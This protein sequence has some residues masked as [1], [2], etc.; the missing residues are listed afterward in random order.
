MKLATRR[1]GTRDGRLLVVSRDLQSAVEAVDIATT[2]QQA[3]ENWQVARPRLEAVFEALQA[4]KCAGAFRLQPEQLAAPLPRAY[5][6][7]DASA[8]HSHGDLLEQVFNLQPPP[9][10][11]TIPLMYQGGSDEFL[12]PCDDIALPSEADGIDFEAEVAIVTDDVPM[13]TK[14]DAA[15]KHIQLAMLVNDVS[16]RAFIPREI[17][18]GFGFL[19]A[20]PASSFSPVAVTLDELGPAWSDGRVKLPLWIYWND[21]A[22]GQ[23]HA[24][25]MGF[26]FGQLIEHAARTRHLR[27]GTIIGSGTVSNE[28]YRKVGS[29]CIAERRAIEKLDSGEPRTGFMKFGD[30]V[31]IT[32]DDHQ[33]RSIFGEIRQRVT[34][35]QLAEGV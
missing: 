15:E 12:G 16:L 30:V 10:K 24:G 1:D 9:D 25:Q 22:F 31:R 29:A 28:E 2:L 14:A 23:P 4:G 27:A 35:Y 20:K 17:K 21:R 18:T 33:G 7:L 32:M 11:R 13:A 26:S 5:Q 19:Q 6:W 3:L 8:F 34:R